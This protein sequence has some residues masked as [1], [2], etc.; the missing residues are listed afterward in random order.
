MGY[1]ACAKNGR[2]CWNGAA[3]EATQWCLDCLNADVIVYS[4]EEALR[5]AA[6][7]T[8]AARLLRAARTGAPEE[9]RP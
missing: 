7:F 3:D 1:C 2:P 5:Y 6:A 8:E 9:E 4:A